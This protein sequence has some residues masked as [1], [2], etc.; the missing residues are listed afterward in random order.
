MAAWITAATTARQPGVIVDVGADRRLTDAPM[1]GPNPAVLGL[2]EEVSRLR[3]RLAQTPVPQE[4]VRNPFSL[5]PI[6][7]P[8]VT[9]V[10]G[11][12][13]V[14]ALERLLEARIVDVPVGQPALEVVLI[15]LAVDGDGVTAILT[16]PTGEVLLVSVGDAVPGGYRV[17]GVDPTSITLSDADGVSHRLALP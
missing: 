13:G 3:G 4:T 9:G 11:V 17:E 16:V 1:A 7:L 6:A 8:G 2:A 5:V 15:G 12:T 14:P 10:T